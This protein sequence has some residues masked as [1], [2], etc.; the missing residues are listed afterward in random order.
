MPSKYQ[1]TTLDFNFVMDKEVA[2]G[3]T[4]ENLKKI[5]TNLSYDISLKDIYTDNNLFS[6]KKSVTY[7]VKLWSDDHTLTGEE[8]EKF[9]KDFIQNAEIFGYKLRY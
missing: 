2:Y 5:D 4:V 9:H 3:E 7:T 8:I 6:N 1:A